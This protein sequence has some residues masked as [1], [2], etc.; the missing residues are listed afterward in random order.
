MS[1]SAHLRRFAAPI[2][3]HALSQRAALRLAA[4]RGR[5]LVLLYHRILPDGTAPDP[6]VP[7]L[8]R[9]LFL[10]H[11]D[12][13]LRVGDIV[14]LTQLLEPPRPGHRPRIALTFDDDHAGYV[15]TVVPQL[16]ARGVTATFFL[17]GRSLHGLPPYWWTSV[18]HSLR[19]HGLESTRRMLGLNERTV[20][21]LALALER[22]A[23]AAQLASRLPHVDE[24]CMTAADIQA[25]VRAGMTIG[26]HTLHHPVL[27][28]LAEG[29]LE[30]A[31]TEGRRELAAAAGAPI[32]LLAYPHGRATAAVADAAERAAFAAAFA[33]GGRP[34]TTT[35]D[36]FLLDRWEPGPLGADELGAAVAMRLMRSPTAPLEIRRKRLQRNET[37]QS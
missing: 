35:S 33:A 23:D 29:P 11:L 16:Q 27:S 22:S 24:P 31:M 13:L 25:M 20:A 28:T 6:I 26:F 37:R 19:A 34:I 10:G 32:D 30:T 1:Y 3:R 9:H 2:F 17:S 7:S 15:G 12:A 14:P 18:E 4:R 5:S 21:D 36:R 8:Q